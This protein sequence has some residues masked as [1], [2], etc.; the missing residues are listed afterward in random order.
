MASES[1]PKKVT[2]INSSDFILVEKVRWS[3]RQRLRKQLNR[4]VA[5][6]FDEAD[7]FLF[8]SG[9]KGQF[10]DDSVYLKSM[11][12]LR[13][14]Q[15][16]FIETFHAAIELHVK[17]SYRDEKSEPEQSAQDNL[18]ARDPVYEKLEIDLAL[19]AMQRKAEKTYTSLLRQIDRK[20]KN[21]KS[22]RIKQVIAGDVLLMAP[23]EGLAQG[24]AV[25]NLPLE[26]RLVFI[27]L[28]ELHVVMKMENVFLDII[29]IIDNVSDKSFVE[30]LYSSSSGLSNLRNKQEELKASLEQHR[31]SVA[32]RSSRKADIVEEAVSQLVSAMC[33]EVELPLFV[34][35]MIRTRWRVVLFLIGLH[36][37]ST[38]V[39]WSEAKHT[40][41]L[42][43]A[44][45]GEPLQLRALDK[46]ALFEKLR[47]GFLLIQMG[48]REQEAFLTELAEFFDSARATARKPA[49]PAR[50]DAEPGAT[51]FEDAVQ[52]DGVDSLS[53]EDLDE[54]AQM[55]G[56]RASSEES[57]QE[58]GP[59]EEFVKEI[60]QLGEKVLV[61]YMING[62]FEPCTLT[63]VDGNP[64]MFNLTDRSA[65]YSVSRSRLGLAV[66]LKQGELRIPQNDPSGPSIHDPRAKT[67]DFRH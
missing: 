42:L 54:I 49:S 24:Q 4:L 41:A 40:V 34:E 45:V 50:E 57:R 53:Q 46:D 30:K 14:K 35:K 29:R 58:E 47:Q 20:Q 28:F 66:A 26:V 11:R 65:K 48:R 52:Q 21:Y 60:D 62:L 12:E 9:Q 17:A 37:G 36:R 61:E 64:E 6:L 56:A 23:I 25:F 2:V 18:P 59:L 32:K 33:G 44:A 1:D 63:R 27:K 55:L 16:L 39:E 10:S 3:V 67:P 38:S 13:A 5:D 51:Q 31:S 22:S 7:D 8:R 15:T 43:V 19:K